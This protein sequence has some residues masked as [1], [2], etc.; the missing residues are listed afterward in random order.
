MGTSDQRLPSVHAQY[1]T[2]ERDNR[3][4]ERY[5]VQISYT[6]HEDNMQVAP[7]VRKEVLADE[8][9]WHMV[10]SSMSDRLINLMN[11]GVLYD[12]AELPYLNLSAGWWSK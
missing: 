6:K 4:T 2:A 8:N 12:L 1:G 11:E 5:N 3:I 7:L 9:S 10:I